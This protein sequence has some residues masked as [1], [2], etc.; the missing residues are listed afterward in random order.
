MGA[1][2]DQTLRERYDELLV[3]IRFAEA[4]LPTTRFLFRRLD[5]SR[6]RIA[7]RGGDRGPDDSLAIG[8]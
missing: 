1:I 8:R 6:K 3:I 2:F 4:P 5:G 7:L